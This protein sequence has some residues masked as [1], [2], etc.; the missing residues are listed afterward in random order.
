M[1]QTD[2]NAAHLAEPR[3]LPSDSGVHH[4]A[5]VR[6]LSDREAVVA[7]M[8]ANGATC[9]RIAVRL[10]LPLR[11]VE[12]YLRQA[13]RILDITDIEEL[14]YVVVAAHY[15]RHASSPGRPDGAPSAPGELE[16]D[17]AH[18][19]KSSPHI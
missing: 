10:A 15:N 9:D 5:E 13:L 11:T 1:R 18:G 7:V 16:S 14:T 17:S 3:Y 4:L 19:S 2:E 12:G 8:V 6:D